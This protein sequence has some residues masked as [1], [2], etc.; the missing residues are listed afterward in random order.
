MIKSEQNSLYITQLRLKAIDWQMLIG[1]SCPHTVFAET[2]GMD[3]KLAQHLEHRREHQ[4]VAL[5]LDNDKRAHI[6][7]SIGLQVM[8]LKR[9][10]DSQTL[11][12]PL[13]DQ[14]NTAEE[15]MHVGNQRI[16]IIPQRTRQKLT[17]L[18][19][20]QIHIAHLN[21]LLLCAT[22]IILGLYLH[23]LQVAADVGTE[24]DFLSVGVTVLVLLIHLIVARIKICGVIEHI[25]LTVNLLRLVIIVSH[26]KQTIELRQT[27][28]ELGV[29]A[30][31]QL[32][33]THLVKSDWRK[34]L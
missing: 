25:T 5:Q 14:R 10:I 26:L 32:H 2:V 11:G 21:T 33:T 30:V 23:E 8:K 4:T 24:T 18:G 9:G 28:H 20:S 16:D 15:I 6:T 13:V 19:I 1:Q 29:R 31:H 3:M 12:L 34:R 27:G 22:V 7:I 17:L